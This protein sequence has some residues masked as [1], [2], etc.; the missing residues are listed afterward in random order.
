MIQVRRALAGL[1]LAVVM[2]AVAGDTEEY[3]LKAKCISFTMYYTSFPKAEP[4]QPWTV[5]ILGISPFGPHLAD[6][7]APDKTVKGRKV[8]LRYLRR[9]A[10]PSGVQVLFICRSEADRLEE[11]LEDVKGKPILT[12]SDIPNATAQGVMVT[13][14]LDQSR[15]RPEVNLQ[16]ARAAGLEF[17]AS[18]LNF[19]KVL[20]R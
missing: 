7:F 18:F 10:D 19:A 5:G 12:L 1:A 14:A 8:S 17:S 3:L 2:T 6:V 16:A 9:G 20:G 13:L 15:I 4:S 11:I